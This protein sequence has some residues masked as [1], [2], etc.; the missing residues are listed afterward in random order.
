[1]KHDNLN[2]EE[3]SSEGIEIKNIVAKIDLSIDLDLSYLNTQLPN[4]TFE[5]EKYPSLI[6][7]P[8]NL[9]TVLITNSGILLFTGGNSKKSIYGAYQIISRE[10]ESVGLPNTGD[11][12]EIK[13]Q[14][15]V[16]TLDLGHN[17]NLNFISVELGFE[18]I[19]YEPEQFPGLIYRIDDGPVVLVFASGKIVITGGKS[20]R[21]II[22]A[23]SVVRNKIQNN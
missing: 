1:M 17:L 11:K 6:F 14:N 3:L 13:I 16:S 5:P 4:S 21:D 8:D 20:D 2:E 12:N 18:N 15:I 9:P 7:R 22:D 23:A 19:E 10:L